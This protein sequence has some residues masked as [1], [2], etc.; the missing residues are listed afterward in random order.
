VASA[1]SSEQTATEKKGR[2]HRGVQTTFWEGESPDG[3]VSPT[4]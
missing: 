1:L 3:Q 2:K 4:A